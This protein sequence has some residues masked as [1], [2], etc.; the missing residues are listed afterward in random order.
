MGMIKRAAS[1][2]R[3]NSKYG[4]GAPAGIDLLS[5]EYDWNHPEK[6]VPIDIRSQPHTKNSERF[7]RDHRGVSGD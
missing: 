2:K 6:C 7:L 1:M 5:F 4:G 3:D